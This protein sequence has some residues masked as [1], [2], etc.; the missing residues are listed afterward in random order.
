MPWEIQFST[1]NT[2]LAEQVRCGDPM[3]L[4]ELVSD[5]AS[6]F[7]AVDATG[8]R[9]GDFAPGIGPFSEPHALSL[10]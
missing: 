9:E 10:V 4:N 1:K 5:L 7:R 8:P 3:E 6:A 2:A